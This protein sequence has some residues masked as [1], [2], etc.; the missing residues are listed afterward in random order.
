MLG[1]LHG[2][3]LLSSG[4]L[5]FEENRLLGAVVQF[6]QLLELD[7]EEQI[8]PTVFKVLSEA[9]VLVL[10]FHALFRGGIGQ[11]FTSLHDI[12]APLHVIVHAVLGG[13]ANLDA[14]AEKRRHVLD[15]ENT[16]WRVPVGLHDPRALF[17]PQT[18]VFLRGHQDMR[19]KLLVLCMPL[20]DGCRCDSVV[21]VF[22]EVGQVVL[23]FRVFED[24]L[25]VCLMLLEIKANPLHGIQLLCVFVTQYMELPY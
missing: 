17:A 24:M 8:Q 12:V 21:E 7:L 16:F 18:R 2:L 4:L 9:A 23:E 25:V 15:C 5:L 10:E 11:D 20:V 3:L 6:E 22:L 1:C 14:L 19:L 13:T